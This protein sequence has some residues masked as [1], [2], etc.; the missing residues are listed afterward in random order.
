[1]YFIQIAPDAGDR[2]HTVSEV[3]ESFPDK[4]IGEIVG[5]GDREIGLVDFL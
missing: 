4:F 3:L 5:V 2:F 1:M